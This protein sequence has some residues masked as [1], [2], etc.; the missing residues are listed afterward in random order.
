MV[1]AGEN[2]AMSMVNSS[3]REVAANL[4]SLFFGV[5]A[6]VAPFIVMPVLGRWGFSGVL[7]SSSLLTALI[8]AFHLA[9]SFPKPAEAAVFPLARAGALLTQPRLWLL[10]LLVF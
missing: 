8:L 5:G 2:T 4:L 1:V 7:K 6:F 9:L 3:Q 10:I